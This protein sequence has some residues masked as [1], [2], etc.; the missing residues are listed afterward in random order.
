MMHESDPSLPPSASNIESCSVASCG[1]TARHGDGNRSY[2]LEPR[3]CRCKFLSSVIRVGRTT[4]SMAHALLL[5][6]VGLSVTACPNPPSPPLAPRSTLPDDTSIHWSQADTL[7]IQ[8]QNDP[9]SDV[10][11]SGHVNDIIKFS[12]PLGGLVVA[13]DTGG[14]WAITTRQ[15]ALPLSGS[16]SS[17]QMTSLALGPDGTRDVYAGTYNA[18]WSPG[19]ILWETDTSAG[20]PMQ[21]WYQVNPT[22]P[23]ASVNKILVVNRL[24]VLACDSGVWW[25]SI[26][27]APSAHGTYQWAQAIAGSGT[28]TA[29]LSTA[30][31]GIAL[32]PAAGNGQPTIVASTSDTTHAAPGQIIF[33]GGWS[34]ENLVLNAASVD[35]GPGRLFLFVGRTSVASCLQDLTSM[36]AVGADANNSQIAGVWRSQDGGRTWSLVTTPPN[37]NG[38][39]GYNNAIAVAGDCHAVAVGWEG[40]QSG[41]TFVSYDSGNSW[42]R[43]TDNIGL[44]SNLH[45]D[46]HALAFDPAD[47]TTLY[48]GSDGGVAPVGGLTQS[49][50]PTFVSN[51]NRQ[52]F[53]MQL[54]HANASSRVNGLVA[55]AL[56]D[57]G[58]LFALLPGAWERLTGCGCDG[59]NVR[60]VGPSGL[61]QATDL[62]LEGEFGAQNFPWNWVTSNANGN[63]VFGLNAQQGISVGSDPNSSLLSNAPVS[64]VRFQRYSNSAGLTML[65]VAGLN[66]TVYGLF[67]NTDGSDLQWESLGLI[68]S[69]QNVSAVSSWNGN[70]VIVGTDAGNFYQ[71]T[72]PYSGG[73]AK[74]AINPPAGSTGSSFVSS[75]VE[76]LPSVAFAAYNVNGNSNGYV[77]Q[78]NGQSW[79]NAS[80]TLPNGLPFTSIEASSLGSVFVVSRA[81]VYSTHNLGS[82][83]M[84]AS[85]GLPYVAQGM[86]LQ[87]VTQPD[88]TS[89]LYLATYGW[90]LWRAKL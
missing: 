68:G 66:Q 36:Y 28:N 10:W 84:I 4:R 77:M 53:D 64:P 16:W 8:S 12:D 11:N 49:A 35:T 90:S 5:A 51:Y 56:Q 39:G 69:G 54:Y 48:I 20:S 83:W 41:G 81:N 80:G 72:Q 70:D 55:G 87:K 71:L 59:N 34:G 1:V 31:S 38:Q 21:A 85:D 24:I 29:N 13:A 74:L 75:V 76:I 82:S 33:W 58:T 50:T 89:Y 67:A 6:I 52:L 22:P 45:A 37:A 46:V 7:A 14:V 62:L 18:A 15:Q 32:G 26:P 79:S 27:P 73:A 19:G 25:S 30:F 42:T 78:W 43:L 47:P 9:N 23:C 86:D 3:W 63:P 60:F 40:G 65:A 61:T 88:G 2:E 17:V 44:Y 57:N